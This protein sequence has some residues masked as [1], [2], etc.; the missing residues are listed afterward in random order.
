MGVSVLDFDGVTRFLVGSGSRD[1]RRL[2]KALRI[3]DINP[4]KSGLNVR[5]TRKTASR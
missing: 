4:P 3:T 2:V 1:A 5:P